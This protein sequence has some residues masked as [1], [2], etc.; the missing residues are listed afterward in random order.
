MKRE[1]IKT[2]CDVVSSTEMPSTASPLEH[3][4]FILAGKNVL[5]TVSRLQPYFVL[6][7]AKLC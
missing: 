4:N 7:P 3:R 1:L 2:K 6:S 5:L